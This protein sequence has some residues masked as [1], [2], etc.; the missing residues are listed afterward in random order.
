MKLI[1]GLGNPG[2]EYRQTRHNFGWLVLDYL[3][4][5]EK[6]QHSKYINAE[7]FKLQFN[8]E[9]IE[10][11]KPLTF[12]NDSGLAVAATVQK[13]QIKSQDLIIVHDDL[14]LPFG[15]LRLGIFK[16][17]AGHNGL[18]SIVHQ[19]NNYDFLRCRLG[20]GNEYSD[21]TDTAK[22]VLNN[23]S[24]TEKKDLNKMIKISADAI[25]YYLQEGLANTTNKY[26]KNHLVK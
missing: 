6:W 15:T 8:Q 21:R 7:Y 12:M 20:I 14:A 18:K 13:H 5:Q 3:A 17:T 1:V 2:K 25:L 11:L 16:S 9:E 10:L 23:F 19:L 22:F 24:A 26:N 4:G